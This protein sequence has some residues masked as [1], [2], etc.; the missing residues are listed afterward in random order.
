MNTA[1]HATSPR[2]EMVDALRGLAILMMFSFHFS[3][4][5]NYFHFIQTDFYHN[6]FWLN[7]RIVIVSTFLSVMG[8][9]LYIAHHKQ[10]QLHKYLRR[11]FILLACAGLV[12][13]G[14]Y[15]MFPQG[16]IFFGIL[17]FIAAATILALPFVRLYWTNLI[18]GVAII[19]LGSTVKHPFF[20]QAPLQWIG[21][22]THKPVTEDYVPL[23]PW[24]GVVLLG[25]F[26]ARWAW[27]ARHFPAISQWRS[28]L[29]ALRVLRFGGRHS[30][31]IYMVHQPIFIGI[32]YAVHKLTMP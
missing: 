13:L 28:R 27:T 10:V 11:L 18:A 14:S 24:F 26:F 9:S 15:L 7:Y 1:T 3:F 25:I 30:L 17:H 4:D 31:L 23:F 32:L 16:M 5:L 2:F 29:A 22:M 6:P 21:M 20:D 8:M 19:V 12:S